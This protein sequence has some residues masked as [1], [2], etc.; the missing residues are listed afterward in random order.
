MAQR[1]NKMKIKLRANDGREVELRRIEDSGGRR[2][3]TEK[4]L[5]GWRSM[6]DD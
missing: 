5:G 3:S 6:D 2:K 1:K 4:D